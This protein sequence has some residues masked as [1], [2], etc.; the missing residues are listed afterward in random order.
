M[1]ILKGLLFNLASR[2]IKRSLFTATQKEGN[3][4]N[5]TNARSD[6]KL[7]EKKRKR[8]REQSGEGEEKKKEKEKEKKKKKKKR[9][10]KEVEEWGEKKEKKCL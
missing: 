6:F 4:I 3:S 9:K 1:K 7:F 10:K 2:K 8:K 5:H